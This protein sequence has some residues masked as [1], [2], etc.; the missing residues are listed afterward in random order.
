M[1]RRV[2]VGFGYAAVTKDREEVWH[3]P[4]EW[5]SWED[6]PTVQ[7]FENM[8]RRDPDHDWRAIMDGPLHGET[9]QRHGPNEWVLVESNQGFA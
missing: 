1:N 8:A 2:A 7:T 3:E 9:Y 4:R 5:T 6:L